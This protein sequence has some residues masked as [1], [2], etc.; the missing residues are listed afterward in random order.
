[1]PIFAKTTTKIPQTNLRSAAWDALP[2]HRVGG[3]LAIVGLS[4][5][6]VCR[7]CRLKKQTLKL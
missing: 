7:Q 3:W 5:V 6:V 1:M 4:E 2:A